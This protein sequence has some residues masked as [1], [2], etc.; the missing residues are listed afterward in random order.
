MSTKFPE[1]EKIRNRAK[2]KVTQLRG[3][4]GGLRGQKGLRAQPKLGGGELVKRARGKA[5]QLMRR[6]KERKPGFIPM[7]KEFK[8]GSRIRK[9]V[10]TKKIRGDLTSLRVP[11]R[12]GKGFSIADEPAK[13]YNRRE[14]I[15]EA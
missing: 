4:I 12:S 11:T 3:R 14:I 1:I 9:V 13:P 6:V 15:I 8:P 10:P 5:D 2:V 7:V